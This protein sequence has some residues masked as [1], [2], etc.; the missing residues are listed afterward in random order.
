[1]TGASS[2][3]GQCLVGE[4][5]K[6]FRHSR[7][8]RRSRRMLPGG[9]LQVGRRS[10]LSSAGLAHPCDPNCRTPHGVPWQPPSFRRQFDFLRTI[11]LGFTAIADQLRIFFSRTL[12]FLR[13][14]YDYYFEVSLYVPYSRVSQRLC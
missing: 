14:V 9:S 10:Y 4:S 2:F 7:R 1:M 5:P 11:P 3:I 13:Q 8:S 12:M 6:R